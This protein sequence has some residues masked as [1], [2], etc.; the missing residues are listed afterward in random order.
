MLWIVFD[1]EEPISNVWNLIVDG[2]DSNGRLTET[3]QERKKL[4][5]AKVEQF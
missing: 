3:N 5:V 1:K 4:P 2:V